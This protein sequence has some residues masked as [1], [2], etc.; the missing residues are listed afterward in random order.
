MLFKC[1]HI[2][3]VTP[4]LENMSQGDPSDHVRQV[5]MKACQVIKWK[6]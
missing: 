1:C 2:P 3:F 6:P 4:Q 5:A